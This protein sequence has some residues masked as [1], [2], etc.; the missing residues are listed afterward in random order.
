MSK[1]RLIVVGY[2]NPGRLDDGLGPAFAERAGRLGLPGV[3]VD[4]NYQLAIEDAATI[5]EFD[6]AV[7]ADASVSGL[8]PF[9]CVELA[10]KEGTCFTTHHVAPEQILHLARALFGAA[11]QAYLIGIRGYAFDEFGERLSPRAEENLQAALAFFR[12]CVENDCA[13][14]AVAAC[15]PRD[16]HSEI[17]PPGTGDRTW[18]KT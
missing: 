5:A 16:A 8:E 1:R 17:P 14:E 11:T 10:P 13:F 4:S 2:G 15:R 18:L 3:A 6:V 9:N 7:F 12:G